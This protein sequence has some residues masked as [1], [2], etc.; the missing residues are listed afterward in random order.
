MPEHAFLRFAFIRHPQT[1][2]PFAT[3]DVPFL[4][5]FL[6]FTVTYLL[7]L[8]RVTFES[9]GGFSFYTASDSS[10]ALDSLCS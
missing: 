10:A 2:I 6:V 9:V 3:I 4:V 5:A 1:L 8:T 7:S